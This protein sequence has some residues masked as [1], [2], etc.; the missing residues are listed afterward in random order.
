MC[1][2]IS[3]EE[4]IEACEDN[5]IAVTNFVGFLSFAGVD[6]KGASVNED[7]AK[8][9][10]ILYATCENSPDKT[11]MM[12]KSSE[13]IEKTEIVQLST[14]CYEIR[15]KDCEIVGVLERLMIVTAAKFAGVDLI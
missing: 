7:Y 14:D 9:T 8:E 4:N 2:I 12:V 6:I 5:V 15:V 11:V 1:L 13:D 10:E 3:F